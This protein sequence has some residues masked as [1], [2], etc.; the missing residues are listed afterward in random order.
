MALEY[1][2]IGP[3]GTGKTTSIR[4][5]VAR[6]VRDGDYNPEDIMLT[7]FSRSAAQ[8]L[9]GAVSVPPENVST[10]HSLARRAT[11]TLPIAEVLPL[12]K[13][14][15][16]SGIPPQWRLNQGKTA[17]FEDGMMLRDASGVSLARYSL[18]RSL[19]LTADDPIWKGLAAFE[20]AWEG[21][22]Q[23]TNSVDFTDM[24]INAINTDGACPSQPPVI[25]VD[26]AQDLTPIQWTLIRK[27]AAHPSVER[28]FVMG[29]PAQAIY[30]FAG[31]RP[32]EMLTTLA[33]EQQHVLNHSYRMPRKIQAH[34]EKYLSRHSGRIM[35][36]RYYT[37]RDEEGVVR[38]LNVTWKKPA[39][40]VDEISKVV[41]A[42][43]TA[44][45]LATCSF[46]LDP[47]IYE[48][49]QRGMMFHN[50]WRRANHKWNP[51]SAR[52]D[53]T[54][55]TMD[56]VQAFYRGEAAHLWL[57]ML[58]A[59]V[60]AMRGGKK[61]VLDAPDE[62]EAWFKPE[63]VLAARAHDM[64]W[65]EQ[66]SMRE[67]TSSVSYAARII[68]TFGVD[69]L[70]DKIKVSVGTIHSVKG[71]EA[72]VVYVYPDVSQAGAEEMS[73]QFGRDASIR[74]GYVAMSRA[75]QEL[76]ICEPA[77]SATPLL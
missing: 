4:N 32:E 47:T 36:G 75:R 11:G 51:I 39:I 28:F 49:R 73:T 8:E 69:A 33:P 43:R 14:W 55:R 57:P 77:G 3:P 76:V 1:R 71:G 45:I 34:A 16:E 62:W 9:A 56:R 26:E 70:D 53:V 27:W 65:L 15:D 74:L 12:S 37:P 2:V 42:G 64:K 60:Y 29:D 5:L 22:K 13:Q 58:S 17:D 25:M 7:S 72:D 41:R 31:A 23:S 52:S 54:T 30:S 50:P 19:N 20:A 10:L 6:W 67:Y 40:L 44:M 59:D 24:I 48:M 61:Y 68:S 46:M 18:A 21:F 63:H 66:Y 38:H 35:D